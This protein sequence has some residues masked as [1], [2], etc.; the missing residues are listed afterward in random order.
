MEDGEQW[1]LE[2]GGGEGEKWEAD[3]LIQSLL[4]LR[5]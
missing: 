3:C 4:P 2:L 1:G 5:V